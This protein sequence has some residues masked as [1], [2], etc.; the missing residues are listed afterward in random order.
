MTATALAHDEFVATLRYFM[1]NAT[2]AIE[3]DLARVA[4]DLYELSAEH[5]PTIE[6]INRYAMKVLWPT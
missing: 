5:P 2:T 6:Y 4:L 3:R 1:E